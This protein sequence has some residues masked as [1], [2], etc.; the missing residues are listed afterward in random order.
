MP[1]QAAFA[2]DELNRLIPTEPKLASD[3]MVQAALAGDLATLLKGEHV[4]GLMRILALTHAG[5]T[6]D[7]FRDAVEGGR[8]FCQL[9]T[10]MQDRPPTY[11]GMTG[12][13]GIW[14]TPSF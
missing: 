3:P 13:T 7:A 6:V 9:T 8:W 1:F 11:R 14:T 2:I 12:I 10:P 4:D 5:M